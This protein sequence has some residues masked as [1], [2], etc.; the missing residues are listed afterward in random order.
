MRE[1]LAMGLAFALYILCPRMT[2]MIAAQSRVSGVSPYAAVVLG[3]LISA[4]MF[5]GLVHVYRTAGLE[6]AVAAA[7]LADLLAALLL[8][9]LDLR[10]GLEL[11]VMTAFVYAGI[12]AAPAVVDAALSA[13]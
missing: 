4:P 2:A 8:G 10:A 11:L 9:T 12:R 5:A 1:L 13:L 7:A 3:A 6:A